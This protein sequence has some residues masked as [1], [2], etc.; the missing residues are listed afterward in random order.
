MPVSRS[1]LT[2]AVVAE[3]DKDTDTKYSVEKHMK[4]AFMVLSVELQ[5]S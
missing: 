3:K 2:T 4:I 5:M 1:R